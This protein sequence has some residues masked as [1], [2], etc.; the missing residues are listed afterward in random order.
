M[1]IQYTLAR[2]A[3]QSFTV[4]INSA[5]FEIRLKNIGQ[6]MIASVKKDGVSIVDGM[7]VVTNQPILPYSSDLGGN[8]MFVGDSDDIVTFN[9]FGISQHF[10]WLSDEELKEL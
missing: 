5:R 9:Q 2:I 1:A 4:N 6:F 8:F 10:R 7:R 3:S